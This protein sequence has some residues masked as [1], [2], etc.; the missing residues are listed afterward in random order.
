MFQHITVLFSFV[1]A[2]AMTHV[3][4]CVS[5]LILARG[6]VRFSGLHALWMLND[7][8]RGIFPA[9]LYCGEVNYVPTNQSLID[10]LARSKFGCRHLTRHRAL[11]VRLCLG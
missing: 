5:K 7:V 8:E 4:S 6:R 11:V 10:G 1:F 9:Q 2:I 3:L